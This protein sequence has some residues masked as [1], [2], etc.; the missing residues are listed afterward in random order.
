MKKGRRVK[1]KEN[2]SR[3]RKRKKSPIILLIQLILIG[4]MIYSGTNIVIWFFENGK[5]TQIM[6]EISDCVQVDNTENVAQEEKYKVNFQELKSKNEDTVAWLKVNGTD[7]EYPIVQG[8]DNDYYL[9]YSFDKT[10]NKAGWPFIDYKNKLD[11]TDKNIIIYG[12][13][14]RDGSMFESLKKI[15]TDEWANNEENRKVVFITEKEKTMY[16]VFS[17]YKIE[18]EDYYLQTKPE[19]FENFV[20]SL[21]KRS[22]KD[23]NVSVG[24]DD[25]ILTLSTCADN[26][27]YRI[28]LHAKKITQ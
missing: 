13:N 17:T 18:V 11:G 23:Y 7:V 21:K 14:R 20:N 3:I 16:E 8:K 5:T 6:E 28:V 10:Y 26:S 2:K 24:K 9:T 1:E 4:I 27:Q 15:L 19:D 12:H 22:T 25:Q